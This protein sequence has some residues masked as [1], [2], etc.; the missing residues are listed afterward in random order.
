MSHILIRF[1]FSFS[2]DKDTNEVPQKL[3]ELRNKLDRAREQVKKLPGIDYSKEEQERQI[4]VLR[5][6]LSSKTDLLRR[7]KTMCNFDIP[8]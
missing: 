2:V 3:T 1:I 5:K 6:Q 4:E 7:Y 8:E